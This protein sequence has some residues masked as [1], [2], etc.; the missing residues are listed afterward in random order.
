MTESVT[1][2]A[3]IDKTSSGLNLCS[4]KKSLP[5]ALIL[6]RLYVKTY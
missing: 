5:F 1:S 4:H 3:M 6:Y 2:V